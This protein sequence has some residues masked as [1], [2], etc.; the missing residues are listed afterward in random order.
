MNNKITLLISLFCTFWQLGI[1]QSNFITTSPLSK[2][3]FCT[4]ESLSLSFTS[5]AVFQA[6]NRFIAQLS[7]VNGNFNAPITLGS[8][9]ATQPTSLAIVIPLGLPAGSNY[10]V[11]VVSTSPAITGTESPTILNIAP[12]PNITISPA[13]ATITPGASITLTAI[14]ANFY[15]WVPTTGLSGSTGSSVIAS[16]ATTTTYTVTGVTGNCSSTTTI[17][18]N[19]TATA[20]SLI[21]GPIE[22]PILCAGSSI[23]ISFTGRGTY[24]S[25][26]VFIAELSDRNGSFLNPLQIG[27]L[28]A[29]TPGIINAFIPNNLPEGTG[30]RIRVVSTSP[31]VESN[32]SEVPLSVQ[33]TIPI[34]AT[35]SPQSFCIG[36][37]SA[38]GPATLTASNI[39]GATYLW[40]GPAGFRS[41]ERIAFI[42]NISTNSAGL[43]TVTVSI[44]ACRVVATAR[45]NITRPKA[46]FTISSNAPICQ[47]NTLRLTALGNFGEAD[48]AYWKGPNGFF[49]TSTIASIPNFSS[50]NAGTYEFVVK[51][52]DCTP[53]IQSININAPS[54][55]PPVNIS[56]NSPVCGGSV[57]TLRAEA[58]SGATY[59]WSGPDGF[60]QSG[61]TVSRQITSTAQAG[62]Y[63]VTITAAGC[64]PSRATTTVEVIPPLQITPT[65]N[66]VCKGGRI[67][68]RAT[69]YPGLTYRWVGPNGL[70]VTTLEPSLLLQNLELTDAGTYA[71]QV[72]HPTCGNLGASV[73]IDVSENIQNIIAQS[74]SPVCIGAEVLL[75]ATTIPNASYR[76]SGPNNFT[77]T[78]PSPI[79][80][81]TST[82]QNGLYTV[83]VV[84]PGCDAVQ[85]STKVEVLSAPRITLTSNSPLCADSS[86]ILNATPF[87]GATY[88]W[89]GPEG[90]DTITTFG[91]LRLS[92]IRFNQRGVYYV[93]VSTPSCGTTQ[94]ST[95]VEVAIRPTRINIIT[96]APICHSEDLILIAQRFENARYEWSGPDDFFSS[97]KDAHIRNATEKNSGKYTVKVTVGGCTPLVETIQVR[98][99]PEPG[100]RLVSNIP[101]CA[102][103]VLRLTANYI[104]GATYNW[105]GPGVTL[106]NSNNNIFE[107]PF[108]TL[109]NLGRYFV[110]ASLF[111][112]QC[113]LGSDTLTI[114]H[115]YLLE[116][117]DAQSNSPVCINNSLLLRAA[118][119]P[120]AT[121]EWFGPNGFRA[122]I[123]NPTLFISSTLQ[124]GVYTVRASL[125]GCKAVE[126]SVRVEVLTPQ[127]AILQDNTP[128]C[129]DSTLKLFTNHFPR[130]TYKW[131]GPNNFMVT[132][133]I[134]WVTLPRVTS[135]NDGIYRVEIQ[136]VGCPSLFAA[137]RV[138]INRSPILRARSNSPVCAGNSIFLTANGIENAN[139]FWSGPNNYTSTE[140][141]PIIPLSQTTQSGIYTVIAQVE[142]C[143]PV[144]DTISVRV[145]PIPDASF[146][147][148]EPLCGE[149]EL[150][151]VGNAYNG[152]R[153][154]WRGPLGLDTTTIFPKL[155]LNNIT[156]RNA[157][158]YSLTIFVPGCLPVARQ[159]SIDADG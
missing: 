29:T 37:Q 144:R 136:T 90:L 67:L 73:N 47:G 40:E 13:T 33:R 10:R 132:T 66:A 112:G 142:G 34:S 32:I 103:D 21:L 101:L 68:L 59:S 117:L 51:E 92:R 149:R 71:V 140:Q 50:L 83:R 115:L 18:V 82:L 23:A 70:N 58:I 122:N 99:A 145:N 108:P 31:R 123:Q 113:N 6:G 152:A 128:L 17:T 72:T 133:S 120:R 65:A 77:S 134:P 148:N 35:I 45:L 88:R 96:N 16:P 3:N 114:D 109:Q 54:Q 146:R 19:V 86:L 24:N 55:T 85:A 74:N 119:I 154:H 84:V 141:N 147:T 28:T 22:P 143:D 62:T 104:E 125:P 156:R 106:T 60:E 46:N 110:S 158:F 118:S 95:N 130:A 20:N 4:G 76:W 41:T 1:A 38:E 27:T 87:P 79:F 97:E 57:L 36:T 2:I 64:A 129:T 63:T 89:L 5:T 8:I 93:E 137:K 124:A 157:G 91:Q 151:L 131:S 39:A 135:L 94:L 14:G 159:Q 52:K 25:N 105:S 9:T 111:N 121:Y 107:I 100:I 43:Y 102:E 80:T 44:G 42:R 30:Y 11:R 98:V 69:S 139:Y 61:A 53:L 49:S 48:S 126:D 12:T 56:S 155:I 7:D 138:V 153:Y 75:K 15:S 150:V 127:S 26:N 81:A 78:I 116:N